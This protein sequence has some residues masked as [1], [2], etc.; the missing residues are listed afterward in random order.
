MRFKPDSRRGR[1]SSPSTSPPETD[2][3]PTG[4]GRDNSGNPFLARV[5][6]LRCANVLSGQHPGATAMRFVFG[7]LLGSAVLVLASGCGKKDA[8]GGGGHP[9]PEG[10]YVIISME[11]DGEPW[12][13]EAKG[14]ESERTIRFA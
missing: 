6:W 7:I 4:A 9:S 8:G 11:A 5:P 10:T 3:D 2:D 13:E 12:P 1:C 14:S